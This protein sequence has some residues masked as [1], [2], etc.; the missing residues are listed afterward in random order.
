[1]ISLWEDGP[2]SVYLNEREAEEAA[3]DAARSLTAL[4]TGMAAVAA[5]HISASSLSAVSSAW[6][7]S[8]PLQLRLQSK[9]WRSLPPVSA[10]VPA[11]SLRVKRQLHLAM[12]R[13]SEL[14]RRHPR[15]VAVR[16]VRSLGEYEL[17]CR[18]PLPVC[19]W[20]V[21][22]TVDPDAEFADETSQLRAQMP[23]QLA[24]FNRLVAPDAYI[25]LKQLS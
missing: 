21:D 19:V 16:V 8:R 6:R 5:A 2:G 3:S 24:L 7:R 10:G 9:R 11:D 22:V 4:L 20:L 13:I 1:M 23:R 25:P 15:C 17:M 14:A 18:Q 12:D